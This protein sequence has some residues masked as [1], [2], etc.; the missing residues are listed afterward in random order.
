MA[1]HVYVCIGYV[2]FQALI[3]LYLS[4][5]RVDRS[6]FMLHKF[7]AKNVLVRIYGRNG[8]G[9]MFWFVQIEYFAFE[10]WIVL[11]NQDIREF[12]RVNVSREI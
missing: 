10:T 1:T 4:R 2:W 5:A 12:I 7:I 6:L 9:C 3:K 11:S 8:S